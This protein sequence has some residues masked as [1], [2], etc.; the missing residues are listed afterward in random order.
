MTQYSRPNEF[1]LIKKYLSPLTQAE[2]GAALLRDDAA[3]VKTKKNYQLVVTMDTLISDVHFVEETPPDL[4]ASKCLRVNISDLAAMG[5]DP[6]YYSLSLSLPDSGNVKYDASWINT[7][8]QG[9]AIEQDLYNVTLI[10]GDTVSTPGPLSLTITAF[11]WVKKDCEIKRSGANIGDLVYVSGTIGDAYLG[12]STLRKNNIKIEQPHLN[13][14]IDRYLRPQPRIDLGRRLTG[15]ASS[16]ID[17]SDGFSQDLGHICTASHVSAT[18]RASDIP[19]SETARAM[20]EV[21]S[22][23]LE[24]LISGGDDYE[25]LFTVPVK[26]QKNISQLAKE[27]EIALTQVGNIEPLLDSHLVTFLDSKGIKVDIASSGYQHF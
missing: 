11:G 4:I 7:F 1:D 24:E 19:L 8:S 22:K 17:I 5:A 2:V 23:L 26:F 14:V 21:N 25:L 9:L 18:I 20:V 15:F 16:A 27:L 3:V 12:L 10:G 13:Y 6:A